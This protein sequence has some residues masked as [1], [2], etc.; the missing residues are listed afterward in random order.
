MPAAS[1]RVT[2]FLLDTVPAAS[3]PELQGATATLP[4]ATWEIP[5]KPKLKM[6]P[7]SVAD[8]VP[9]CGFNS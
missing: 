8:E 6:C 4:G 7:P 1:S 5:L 2:V 9:R 3:T